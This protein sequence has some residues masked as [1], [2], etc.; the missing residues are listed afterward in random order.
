M[1]SRRPIPFVLASTNHG[2]FIVNRNDYRMVD[3]NRGYGVGYQLLN[4]SSFD[5]EEVSFVMA[6]LS[7]R[8]KYFGDGVVG[9]DCGAN[10]GVH[11]VEW[12]KHM[13]QWGRVIAFEAQEKVYYALAGNIAINN[14]L[15]AS[16]QLA[17]VGSE[18]KEIKIPVPD[19]LVPASF[20]SLELKQNKSNEFIG[21]KIDYSDA[22]MLAVQQKTIDSL[23][24]PRVDLIKIDVEGMEVDVL[25]GAVETIKRCKP[26][27]TIEII[28]T[29]KVQVEAFLMLHGYQTYP[30][31]INIL[32]IHHSD[33]GV[34]HINTTE[35]GI[36]LTI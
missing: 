21:Q 29:D 13:H 16:A 5:Q 35:T 6:L 23:N 36:N 28:K 34:T 31:G 11:T 8:R 19:Y 25:Q 1:A 10:I 7:L 3:A 18:N 20:G 9:L 27:M 14:C 4:T 12:A 32:A 15:N 26:M 33:P 24:L 2:T 30:M 22:A 17:A